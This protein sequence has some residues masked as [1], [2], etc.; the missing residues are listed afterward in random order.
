MSFY[1]GLDALKLTICL[2]DTR[3]R[4]EDHGVSGRHGGASVVVGGR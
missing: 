2:G 1:V 3:G 4:D